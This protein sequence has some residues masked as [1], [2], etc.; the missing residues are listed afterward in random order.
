MVS[1]AK[2]VFQDKS[3]N[4]VKKAFKSTARPITYL[5]MKYSEVQ[6]YHVIKNI[7]KIYH[8]IFQNLVFFESAKDSQ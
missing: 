1:K 8:E 7:S 2:Y 3:G 4:T 6:I 5:R